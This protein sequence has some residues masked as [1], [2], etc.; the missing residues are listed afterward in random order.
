MIYQTQED[1]ENEERIAEEFI[2]LCAEIY[3]SKYQQAKNG[4]ERDEIDRVI[5]D[6]KG[7]IIGFAE[8]KT[9]RHKFGEYGSFWVDVDKKESAQIVARKYC[10]SAIL[11]IEWI[12]G[13]M[14]WIRLDNLE[15]N[16]QTVGRM[17]RGYHRDVRPAMRIDID[18]INILRDSR[19]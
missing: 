12:C 9:K 18:R 15:G 6:E 3:G 2:A 4:G 14:G 16:I 8:I 7:K 1:L 10:V 5:T 11:V 17:D 19:A 13:S